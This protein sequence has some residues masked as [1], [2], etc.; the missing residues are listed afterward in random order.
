MKYDRRQFASA[1][2]GW[3][4]QMEEFS[5]PQW[6]DF[7]R[8]ELYMDQVTM[9]VNQYLSAF[10]LD[11]TSENA[12]TPAMI[13]N[14]V[15]MKIV[16]APVKKRYTRIHLAYLVMVC[17]L[18]QTLSMEMIRKLLPVDLDEEEMR[19]AYQTFVCNQKKTFELLLDLLDKEPF[20]ALEDGELADVRDLVLQS[21]IFSNLSRTLTRMMLTLQEKE[22]N[23]E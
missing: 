15:K 1:F 5:L 22:E 16:P 11:K 13:N 23:C 3:R 20:I 8:L 4:K 18:K 17:T 2:D 10:D 6:G 12:V 9:L 14:Y 7:P 19:V 21:A